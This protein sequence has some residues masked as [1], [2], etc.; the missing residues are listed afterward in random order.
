MNSEED[1]PPEFESK[2]FRSERIKELQKY[3]LWLEH[4]YRKRKVYFRASLLS[5]IVLITIAIMLY[6]F[7]SSNRNLTDMSIV[8]PIIYGLVALI[9]S[10]VISPSD[11]KYRI[12]ENQNELD[13]LMISSSSI[14]E[15]AE[16]LFRN[17]Q[18]ELK[19]YYDQ[20]LNH[21]SQIFITGIICIVVGFIFIG[22]TFYLLFYTTKIVSFP[23]KILT[24]GIGLVSNLFTSYIGVIYLKMFSE[25]VKSLTE[26]HNRLVTTHNLHFGNFILSKITDKRM[27]EEG[28]KEFT[29]E[30]LKRKDGI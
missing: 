26:F 22:L 30:I 25:T 6:A 4:Q 8:L 12:Y 28:L 2:K 1:F 29:F 24:A 18:F 11:F 7:G 13:L 21:S 16:K 5:G 14:E 27:R 10:F 9:I 17:H 20:T 15:R 3:I 19:R 23:E